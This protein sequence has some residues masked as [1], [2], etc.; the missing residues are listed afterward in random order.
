MILS[1]AYSLIL[2][3][4][5]TPFAAPQAASVPAPVPTTW[6]SG[7][8]EPILLVAGDELGMAL[9]ASQPAPTPPKLL[10]RIAA[11]NAAPA[12]WTI[13]SGDNSVHLAATH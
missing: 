3:L 2:G 8:A 12:S 1:T 6:V 9:F 10:A 13:M 7:P 11:A 5:I 4:N